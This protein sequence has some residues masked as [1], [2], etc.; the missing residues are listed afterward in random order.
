M[1]L[2]VPP[3]VTKNASQTTLQRNS[4][5]KGIPR[6]Y[7]GSNN[8]VKAE[9]SYSPWSPKKKSKITQCVMYAIYVNI[10][11]TKLLVGIFIVNCFDRCAWL[12]REVDYEGETCSLAGLELLYVS[13]RL[14]RMQ[15]A[16]SPTFGRNFMPST[17]ANSRSIVV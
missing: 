13:T 14:R 10:G 17:I 1:G 7:F 5:G 8:A 11:E 3:Q 15:K 6:E 2:E 9:K 12:K 4:S 16:I